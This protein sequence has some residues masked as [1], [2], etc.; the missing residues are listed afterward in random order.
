MMSCGIP[1]I[2]LGVAMIP[3][4]MDKMKAGERRFWESFLS[5]A[6]R[7]IGK[8]SDGTKEFPIEPSDILQ[9][10]YIKA[11]E[12]YDGVKYCQIRQMEY[13]FRF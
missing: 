9:R 6:K 10:Q 3:E 7:E 5:R 4:V 1:K 11:I 13:Y 2:Q 8:A 12:K